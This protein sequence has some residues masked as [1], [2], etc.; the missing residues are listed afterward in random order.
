MKNAT[1]A[2]LFDLDGTLL[3]NDMDVF[4]P[5]YFELLTAHMAHILPPDEFLEHLMQATQKMLSNDG[6]AT[7]QEVFASA[8]YPLAGRS[9]MEM[10][11]EFTDFYTNEY[12]ALQQYTWRKP[13]A[14]QVVQQ[15]FDLG[16]DVVIATNP[17]FPTAAVKQRLE[18]AGV[19]DF[20]FR[21]VTTYENSCA[22]KPNLLYFEQ[23]LETIGYP[24]EASL[25]IGDEDMDMVA[26]H[27]GCSTFLVP[28]PRTSL[29]PTT[30][31]PDYQ[32]TLSDVGVLLQ[33]WL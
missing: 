24:P 25:V 22:T 1:R 11:M 19:D 13:E 8:F 9:R 12:P 4:L 3:S 32:G 7:N 17:L 30:P 6:R 15:A 2:I 16:Y 29:A 23:I 18:W 10:E 26:A 5:R 33:S 21:L 31:E 27:L 20:A 28:G 14:R